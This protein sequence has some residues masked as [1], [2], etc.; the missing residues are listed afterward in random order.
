[1]HIHFLGPEVWAHLSPVPRVFWARP[2]TT[3]LWLERLH[4][5]AL[6][7]RPPAQHC[8]RLLPA[9]PGATCWKGDE[10]AGRPL[11]LPG[12][13]S[14]GAMGPVGPHLSTF[15]VRPLQAKAKE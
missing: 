4:L 6:A 11:T 12:N 8:W 7:H 5:G 10:M 13:G 9:R 3:G 14:R 15:Y 2:L 1:M